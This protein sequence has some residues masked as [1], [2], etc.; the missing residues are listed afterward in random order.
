MASSY[1]RWKMRSRPTMPSFSISLKTGA[2][3]LAGE[4]D[5]LG[6]GW[7]SGWAGAGFVWAKSAEDA[8]TGTAR[9]KTA[10]MYF[11]RILRSNRASWVPGGR[12]LRHLS[13]FKSMSQP[14]SRRL[15][16]FPRSWLRRLVRNAEGKVGNRIQFSKTRGGHI[17]I[18]K[19]E[20]GK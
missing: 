20:A 7:V 10:P 16:L 18:T 8:K 19:G 6:A 2:G 5:G 3:W 9:M 17:V 11:L 1:L 14:R 4:G 15:G 13:H 12:S